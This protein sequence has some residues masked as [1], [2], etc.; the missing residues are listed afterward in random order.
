MPLRALWAARLLPV[1]VLAVATGATAAPAKVGDTRAVFAKAGTVLRAEPAATAAPVATLPPRTT[2]RVEEVQDPWL[3]VQGSPGPGKPAVSGWLRK[4]ELIEVE[5]LAA[6]PPPVNTSAAGAA[7]VSERDRMAAGRQFDAA[8]ERGYRAQHADLQRGYALVD[9]MER[10]T[11]AMDPADSVEFIVGAAIGGPNPDLD[12]PARLPA[13]PPPPPRKQGGIPAG[14]RGLGGKIGERFGGKV[15]KALGEGLEAFASADLAA[16]AE[17]LGSK[18]T[19]DHEYY[20]GRAVAAHAFARWGA[21]PNQRMRAYVRQVGDALVRTGRR[22]MANHGGYHFDVLNCDDVNGISGPGGFVLV[23]RGA[24]LACQTEDELASILAHELSHVGAKH[25]EQVIRASKAQEGRHQAFLKGAAAATGVDD[26]RW[27]AALVE[28]FGN[29]TGEMVRTSSEH[30][31]GSQMEF[32]ADYGGTLLLQ[33][34]WYDW[35]A[36]RNVLARIAASGHAH[37]GADHAPPQQRVAA[38]DAR[39]Q[40]MGV[41][42]PKDWVRPERMRRFNEAIGR[43]QPPAPAP[44]PA[45]GPSP[46]PPA[47]GGFPPPR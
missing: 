4:F 6:A 8:T 46:A 10:N 37:G 34:C 1:A 16:R 23:T 2:V 21:E 25:A 35:W 7:G 24:V 5:K 45:P 3:K 13:E 47:P 32:S 31:Y 29:V 9:E 38:L 20:L 44:A 28:Y 27:G 33:E 17:Q 14:V 39:L 40:A 15:G 11:A 43:A 36:M 30:A 19:V 22:V 12:L 18:F 41:Y 42:S 26:S